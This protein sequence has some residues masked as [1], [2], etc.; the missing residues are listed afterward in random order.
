MNARRKA[1]PPQEPT[2]ATVRAIVNGNSQGNYVP[3]WQPLRPGAEDALKV[4]TRMGKRLHYRDGRVETL[5]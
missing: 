2:I 1:A 4:P 5:A 3:T